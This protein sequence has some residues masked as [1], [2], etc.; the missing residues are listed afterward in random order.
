MGDWLGTGT[1]APRLKTY[2]PFKMAR[3]FVRQLQLKSTAEWFAFCKGQLPHKGKLPHDIPADPRSSYA[4]R[5]WVSMGDWLGTGMVAYSLRSYRSFRAARSYA[6][7][8]LLR[9][10]YEWHALCK[11]GRLPADIPASPQYTYAKKGWLGYRDW[12]GTDRKVKAKRR[13]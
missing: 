13:R 11:A 6:R 5:G 10:I 7:S 2:R 4:K 12:L 8:L 1:I 9:D 3:A